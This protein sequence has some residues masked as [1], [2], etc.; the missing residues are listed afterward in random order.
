[1]NRASQAERSL[2]QLVRTAAT[3]VALLG[4]SFCAKATPLRPGN[5]NEV[6][7]RVRSAPLDASAR[8]LRMARQRLS[9]EPN[10]LELAIRF[11]RLAIERNSVEGDPRYLG[12]AQAALS[13]WWDREDIPSRVLVLRG[14]IRQAQHDFKHALADLDLAVER[15]PT[16]A[17]AWLTKSAVLAVTGDYEKARQACI[18]LAQLA[19]GLISLAAAA[20][21]SCLNGDAER[22]CAVLRTALS[23]PAQPDSRERVWAFTI[24]GEASRRLGREPEAEACFKRV[25]ELAPRDVYALGAYADLLLDQGRA[26]DAA[27]LLSDG[28]RADALL[29]RLALA[30]SLLRPIPS[31][32]A[33]HTNNLAAR[34]QEGHLRGDFVHLRE[35]A[36]FELSLAKRPAAAL[37]LAQENWVIQREPADA[38]LLLECARQ[39]HDKQAAAPVLEFMRRTHIQD[40]QLNRLTESLEP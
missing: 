10:N 28:E 23:N 3:W 1:M 13:P 18:P 27:R 15:D 24:L 21:V 35:E 4:V 6:L 37:R 34:F 5:G 2:S 7:E 19:P 31:N 12:R 39:A 26:R 40:E 11:A 14:M 32:F 16:D 22:G 8:E 29:L 33:M 25:L 20:N 9:A 30:E 38:R 36:Q 17:Q